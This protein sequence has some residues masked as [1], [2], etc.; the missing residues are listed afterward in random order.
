MADLVLEPTQ[1]GGEFTFLPNGDFKTS[2]GL[3][4]SGYI[5][6]LS[7]PYWGNDLTEENAK[8]KSRIGELFNEILNTDTRKKVLRYATEALSFFL[9]LGIAEDVQIDATIKT[10]TYCLINVIITQPD[11]TILDFSYGLN[12]KSQAI[13]LPFG[14]II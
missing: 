13:E 3:Y 14:G 11:G 1:S 2:D 9:D 8:Y 5:A 10:A 12:W 7:S 4:N 6:L